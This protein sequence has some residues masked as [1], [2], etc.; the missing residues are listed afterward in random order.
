MHDGILLT[1][2]SSLGGHLFQVA[3]IVEHG[4]TFLGE[5]LDAL[6]QV[7]LPDAH[8]FEGRRRVHL[9]QCVVHLLAELFSFFDR[10]QRG[11]QAA[12]SRRGYTATDDG[13]VQ[14]I[15]GVVMETTGHLVDALH[16]VVVARVIVDLGEHDMHRRDLGGTDLG[17]IFRGAS[18]QH[19]AHL[20][21]QP[22]V[23][24]VEH[25]LVGR[26]VQE[27]G[28]LVA[29]QCFEGFR[30][31]LDLRPELPRTFDLYGRFGTELGAHHE[32]TQVLGSHLSDLKWFLPH[33]NGF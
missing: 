1:C 4:L 21:G 32:D 5:R 3:G 10:I 2:P 17:D 26:G 31:Y 29:A 7:L 22:A 15:E 8:R 16:T 28:H 25:T 18:D 6:G 11:L 9:V 12:R 33:G 13:F 24:V 19:V 23:R 20:G 30:R 14:G 27:A